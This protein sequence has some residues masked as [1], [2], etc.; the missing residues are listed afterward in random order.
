MSNENPTRI[1]LDNVRLA[2]HSLYTPSAF[3]DNQQVKFSATVLFEK[4]SKQ[5]K[6]I[7]A[8][9]EQVAKD[10]WG[11]QSTTIL[12]QLFAGDKMCLHD[13]AIKADKD[14][15]DDTLN[16]LNATSKS[17]PGLFNRTREPVTEADGVIYSG[18]YVNFIIEL[19]AQDN[20]YGKRINAELKGVQFVGDGERLGGASPASAEDFPELE[21][22]GG[23][24]DDW[25][26][27]ETEAATDDWDS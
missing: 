19:W 18:C 9:L 15:Y 10:K 3:Q 16:Y 1:R 25:N 20:Q 7:K 5:A 14:G 2:G 11:A 8:L 26:E 27:P 22:E 17:R 13:G 23:A 24:G 4:K 6:A 21:D 12:K